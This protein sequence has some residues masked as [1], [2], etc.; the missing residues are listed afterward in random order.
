MSTEQARDELVHHMVERGVATLTLDSPHNRNALSD[1]LVRQLLEALVRAD[2]DEHVRAI[3]LTHTG[4]T[5]CAGVDLTEAAQ[6]S[7]S[8]AATARS[9]QLVELLRMILTLGTP[10][11]ASIDGHVRAG[12]M[13]IIGAC[14]VVVSGPRSTFAL[15]EARIGVAPSIISLV[16]LSRLGDRAASRLCLTGEAFGASEAAR[17]GFVTE[18]AQDR[19]AALGRLLTDFRAVSPQGLRE[20]KLLVNHGILATFDAGR[21][22]VIE[23]STRLFMSEEAAEGMR[24]FLE[25]R[26]PRWAR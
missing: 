17:I 15:T 26:P 18:A 1:R 10:V 21:D 3:V 16:V 25:K 2:E 8:E 12:G 14:D 9:E 5:F 24:A 4:N 13:G 23:Q 20:T 22:R 11:V 19:D 7:G 6:N